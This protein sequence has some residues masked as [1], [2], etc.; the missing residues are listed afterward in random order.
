MD[1][2]NTIL[3]FVKKKKISFFIKNRF[4]HLITVPFIVKN[5]KVKT[6]GH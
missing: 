1:L 6:S 4:Y 2:E 3:S 5:T